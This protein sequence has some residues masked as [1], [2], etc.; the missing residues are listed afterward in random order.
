MQE[1]Q[2]Q[3]IRAEPLLSPSNSILAGFACCPDAQAYGSLFES[4]DLKPAVLQ[5][6]GAVVR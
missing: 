6:V 4:R 5:I 3:E 2:A 1:S